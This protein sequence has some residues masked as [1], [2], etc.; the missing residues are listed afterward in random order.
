MR[1]TIDPRI[2]QGHGLCVAAAPSIF[3]MDDREHAVVDGSEVSSE[4][5]ET[6][7][8]AA[9]SCPEQAITVHEH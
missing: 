7:R 9:I 6:V 8:R 2:C 3:A 1:V 5:E 4:L